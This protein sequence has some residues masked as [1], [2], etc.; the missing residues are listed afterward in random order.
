MFHERIMKNLSLSDYM[1]FAPYSPEESCE[2][3]VTGSTSL[4]P[5]Q[6]PTRITK[7]LRDKNH[8]NQATKIYWGLVG[9]C[10]LQ[11]TTTCSKEP[12]NLM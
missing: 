1:E 7:S 3:T 12:R 4:I 10:G 5:I 8:I 2:I 6:N 11:P 9:D